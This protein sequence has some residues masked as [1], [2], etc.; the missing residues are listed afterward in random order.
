MKPRLIAISTV[1]ALLIGTTI[2]AADAANQAKPTISEE[3]SAAL[4]RMGQTLRAEQ[5]SFQARTGCT[6]RRTASR[7]T[8]STR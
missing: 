2:P 7:F 8:S 6:R 4:L 3:A 1:L 5:F